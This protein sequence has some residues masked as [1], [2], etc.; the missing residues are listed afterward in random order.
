MIVIVILAGVFLLLLFIKMRTRRKKVAVLTAYVL[1]ILSVL[2]SLILLFVSTHWE[3]LLSLLL[4][5]YVSVILF[6]IL[7][8]VNE[9]KKV[10][11]LLG[12]S[13]LC[14]AAG[15]ATEKYFE[16]INEIPTVSEKNSSLYWYVPFREDNLL[17]MPDE[18]PAAKI[19][20]NLPVMDGATA[21]FPVYASFMQAV[22]SIDDL[23]P[24]DQSPGGS[25][26]EKL[27]FC[28]G[29]GRA[30]TNLL[31][32]KADII[33]CA[34][35]SDA[36]LEQFSDKGIK[37]KLVPIGREAFVFFVNRKNP[38]NN[39][40][41]ENINLIYSGKLKNW[42]KLNGN[43]QGI[44]AFQRTKNSGSQTMLEKIMGL[45]IEK[46]RKENVQGNMGG[47]ISQVA[48]YRNFSNAIGYSFLFYASEMVQNDQIKLLSIDGIYPS[49]ETILNNSYPF[50]GSFYA[51]Y[52]DN[53]ET[54][55]NIEPLINWIL[56]GQGQTLITKTGYVSITDE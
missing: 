6:L 56:S 8:N 53:D 54:N 16:R 5:F 1:T 10:F 25:V 19:T 42:K 46:P 52:I 27:I 38:V 2:G 24:P 55:E 49:K 29:T 43:N 12:V 23:T 44:I 22:Y 45:P 15:I 30:Y 48:D 36:Q 4:L 32:G 37:L 34:E 50:S 3:I 51:I 7:W 28:S 18:E 47:V 11:L 14:I 17:V 41:I 9:S 13:A 21:L 33:F 40:T 35:P 20:G 26:F 31:E 39:I